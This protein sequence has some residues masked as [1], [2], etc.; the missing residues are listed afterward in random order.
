MG[1]ENFV[2]PL[3]TLSRPKYQQVPLDLLDLGSHCIRGKGRQGLPTQNRNPQRYPCLPPVSEGSLSVL[4][5]L[6]VDHGRNWKLLFPTEECVSFNA[7]NKPTNLS[8]SAL[9]TQ[10]TQAYQNL[11]SPRCLGKAVPGFRFGKIQRQVQNP[12]RQGPAANPVVPG[13]ASAATS[14]EFPQGL[15]FHRQGCG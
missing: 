4:F 15:S 11:E 10:A 6:L 1:S 12:L 14:M 2:E 8:P 3:G 5:D 9:L 7:L 13:C